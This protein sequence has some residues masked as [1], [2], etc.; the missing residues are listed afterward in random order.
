[1]EEVRQLE[2]RKQQLTEQLLVM[3][4]QHQA[5]SKQYQEI[6][7]KIGDFTH[8]VKQPKPIEYSIP[9]E[10]KTSKSLF[11]GVEALAERCQKIK[12][13][14]E[15][16]SEVFVEATMKEELLNEMQTNGDEPPEA[17]ESCAETNIQ[18]SEI[19]KRKELES[20]IEHRWKQI[21]FLES[22]ESKLSEQLAVLLEMAEGLVRERK[23][24]NDVPRE[25]CPRCMS[26]ASDSLSLA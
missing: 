5:M 18:S 4:L 24:H 19:M 12:A 9:D 23:W 25:K 26:I 7:K 1:M 21:L 6:L 8:D 13:T 17:Q 22:V 10:V 15:S 2:Q 16:L 3:D 20:E 11:D 14:F